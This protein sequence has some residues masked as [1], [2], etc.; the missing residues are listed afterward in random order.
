MTREAGFLTLA[1]LALPIAAFA[2][3]QGIDQDGDGLYSQSEL[4]AAY[5]TLTPALF[6]LLDRDA[7]GQVSPEEYHAGLQAKLL[8][9]LE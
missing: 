2:A 4:R 3:G 9:S 8:P 6:A 5:P 7:D 1:A